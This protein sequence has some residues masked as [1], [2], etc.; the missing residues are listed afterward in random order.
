MTVGGPAVLLGG[1]FG[2]TRRVGEGRGDTTGTRVLPMA[3]RLET[4]A[5]R[6][7]VLVWG[8]FEKDEARDSRKKEGWLERVWNELEVGKGG[9]GPWEGGE[10][11]ALSVN[12]LEDVSAERVEGGTG[13]GKKAEVRSGSMAVLVGR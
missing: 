9:V 11:G 12:R 1:G 10:E 4:E 6:G 13:E 7:I 8:R 3:V 2:G 5:E